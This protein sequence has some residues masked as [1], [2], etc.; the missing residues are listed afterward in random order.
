MQRFFGVLGGLILSAVAV[1]VQAMPDAVNPWHTAGNGSATWPFYNYSVP[2]LELSAFSKSGWGDATTEDYVAI[3][4]DGFSDLHGVSS[5]SNP[6]GDIGL[7]PLASNTDGQQIQFDSSSASQHA[8]DN[9]RLEVGNPLD[10]TAVPVP[11][12]AWLF[13]P[14]MLGLVAVARRHQS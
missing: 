14:G 9:I 10:I 6:V 4:A 3:Q 8:M 1:N 7:M 2:G 11:T 5:T 12:V 13:G